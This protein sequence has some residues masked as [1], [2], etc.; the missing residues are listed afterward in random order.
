MDWGICSVGGQSFNSRLHEFSIQRIPAELQE[1]IG[2]ILV[3]QAAATG[4]K[5]LFQEFGLDDEFG[6]WAFR[7]LKNALIT[8]ANFEGLNLSNRQMQR[9]ATIDSISMTSVH[10]VRA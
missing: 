5:S 9:L 8:T 3:E 7:H 6:S 4:S 2:P 1:L 10:K